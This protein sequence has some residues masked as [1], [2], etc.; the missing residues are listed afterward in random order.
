[1]T[2]P[3]LYGPSYSTYVRTARLALAEKEVP[4]ELVVV[5]FLQGMPAE[6]LTRHPFAKV[7]VFAQDGYQ[8]YET[9]AIT[10]YV[11]EAFDGPALQPADARSRARMTQIISLLDAYAYGSMI[12][13]VMVPRVVAPLMGGEPDEEMISAA[14]PKVQTCLDVLETFIGERSCLM[15]DGLTLADLHLVPILTYFRLAPE[16]GPLLEAK[17]ALR[18]WYDAMRARSSVQTYCPEELR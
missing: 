7:P 4:Y 17:P 11:D 10:R 9:V 3:I 14:L 1:M 5:D 15:G 13:Q 8:L 16:S 6:H 2:T 12:Q 18:R